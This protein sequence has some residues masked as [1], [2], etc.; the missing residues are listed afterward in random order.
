MARGRMNRHATTPSATAQT[1][2]RTA[3]KETS[4]ARIIE[5]NVLTLAAP[6]RFY[7]PGNFR[8]TVDAGIILTNA[9]KT[10]IIAQEDGIAGEGS[11]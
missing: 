1:T 9:R 2:S 4:I 3:L 5:G 11:D 6:T 7:D 10:Q 8:G